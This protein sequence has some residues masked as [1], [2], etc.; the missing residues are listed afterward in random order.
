[1]KCSNDH[2]VTVGWGN[3][4]GHIKRRKVIIAGICDVTLA[5]GQQH[6]QPTMW[7]IPFFLW[8]QSYG[9]QVL[10]DSHIELRQTEVHDVNILG[11]VSRHYNS[12]H[13]S[14]YPVAKQT[15][16]QFMSPSRSRQA[17]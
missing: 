11:L 8:S 1:M 9:D 5:A 17:F 15:F 3:L 10:C 4:V 7:L 16:Q 6:H 13:S 12:S 2:H 14:Y